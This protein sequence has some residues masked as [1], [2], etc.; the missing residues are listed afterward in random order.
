MMDWTEELDFQVRIE[1]LPGPKGIATQSRMSRA[2][3]TKLGDFL[4]RISENPASIGVTL[5]LRDDGQ[6]T[7]SS[8]DAAD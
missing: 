4:V 3:L 8:V 1:N 7:I 6:V 2:D 5:E